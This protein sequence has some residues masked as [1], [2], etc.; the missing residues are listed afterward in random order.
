MLFVTERLSG[1]LSQYIY[2]KI[3]ITMNDFR[4]FS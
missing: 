1:D 4:S 3:I 2:V